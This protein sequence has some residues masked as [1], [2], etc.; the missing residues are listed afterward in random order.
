MKIKA[1]ICLFCLIPILGFSQKE[2][3]NWYFGS[4]AGLT[5][6]SGSPVLL[7]GN[8]YNSG[9]WKMEASV[10]DS[11]GNLLFFSAG[12][13]VFD[14]NLAV[15]PNGDG[16][17][18]GEF[19]GEGQFI[20]VV[21]FLNDKNKY[22]LFTVG[23]H[24]WPPSLPVIGMG[25]SALD[26]LTAIRHHNNKD[27]WV[28][29]KRHGLNGADYLAYLVTSAGVDTTPIVSQSSIHRPYWG[30]A[31]IT[32]KDDHLRIS[33][34]GKFLISRDSLI[35]VCQFNSSTGKVKPKF[36]FAAN[37]SGSMGGFEFSIDSRYLYSSGSTIEDSANFF[38]LV[39]YDMNNQDSL[40]FV[41]NR[42]VVGDSSGYSIQMAPDGK[43]YLNNL[44]WDQKSLNV[45]NYPSQPGLSCGYQKNILYMPGQVWKMYY[46]SLCTFLQRYKGYVHHSGYL[47]S[48]RQHSLEF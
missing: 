7:P 40:S 26:Q 43:I 33:P 34:D 29:A 19:E 39:Q 3:N 27:V 9:G 2:F 25:D 8:P 30:N 6:N 17:L 12:I 16:L 15:M 37:D 35:E 36:T 20:M 5:F 44:S 21:P 4:Y 28:V 11:N 14:R 18:G 10:S 23:Y 13:K 41:Q 31:I 48:T 46:Q 32:N 1:I 45:I 47:A 22:Y 38:Y 24:E 42:F